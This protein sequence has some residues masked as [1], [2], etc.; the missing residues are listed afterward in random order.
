[1]IGAIWTTVFYQPILNALLFFYALFGENLGFAI[2]MVTVILRAILFP[3][4]KSQYESSRKLRELQPQL[5]KIQDKYK[6]NPQKAQEEQMKLYK[7]VGY[8]PLGCLFSMVIPFPFL[9][10]IY[11]VIRAFSSGGDITGVYDFVAN[12]VGMNGEIVIDTGFFGLDLSLSYL[13]LAREHGYLTLWILPY[14]VIAILVGLS[15]YFSLQ[16][17][18][19]LMGVDQ[20]DKE[21][22]KK[23]K[24]KDKKKKKPEEPDPT[25]M[26]G[27]MSKSMK[28]TFP[29][30]TTFI[31]LSLPSAVSL[32]WI[33]QSWVPVLMYLL[34]NKLIERL[35]NGKKG[36]K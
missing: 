31:A 29:A 12:F 25:A 3:F 1:M 9:I 17:N 36:K 24:E 32:Y 16:F 22:E 26:L 7:K 20:D 5:K 19:G 4:M 27:D 11:Q 33:L 21:K 35:G 15:Q 2:I 18:Q 10:A 23:K 14:L 34:Y 13:P 6:R 28:F 30:M 8:N